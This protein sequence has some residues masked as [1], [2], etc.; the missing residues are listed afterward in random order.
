MKKWLIPLF[1]FTLVFSTSITSFAASYY[2]GTYYV[3]LPNGVRIMSEGYSNF[4]SKP[5]YIMPTSN[6]LRFM[7]QNDHSSLPFDLVWVDE[8]NNYG[9]LG[10]TKTTTIGG[11]PFEYTEY[12]YPFTIQGNTVKSL[13][14]F[15][16]SSSSETALRLYPDSDSVDDATYFFKNPLLEEVKVQQ[17]K[18]TQVGSILASYLH[19]LIP[20]G[21]SLLVL[22]IS[23]PVL[24]RALRTFLR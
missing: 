8:N 10:S 16:M 3:E 7:I 22:L 24:L 21:V 2:N 5:I 14:E 18:A 6:G 13:S 4:G 20:L 19:Y 17:G 1:V 15:E 12:T 9:F 11:L 23:V